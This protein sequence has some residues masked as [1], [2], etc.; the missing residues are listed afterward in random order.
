M[1]FRSFSKALADTGADE[2][3][4]PDDLVAALGLSPL[5]ATGQITWRGTVYPIRYAEA[6]LSLSQATMDFRWRA[7]IGFSPARIG[8]AQPCS[9]LV[10]W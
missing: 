4:F 8:S 1:P 7:T 9:S 2:T 5:P 10:S 3:V 6:L